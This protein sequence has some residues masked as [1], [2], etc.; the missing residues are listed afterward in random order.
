MD[1]RFVRLGLTVAPA[2]V[3]IACGT[4]TAPTPREL[5]VERAQWQAQGLTNYSYVWEQI[6]GG[7][8]RS[9]VFVATGDTVPGPL[10]WFPTID[11]MFDQAIAAANGHTLHAIVFDHH[12]HYPVRMD[13]DG[14]AD[15]S[16]S[17]LASEL[18]PAP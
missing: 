14:P 2:L 9:A 3:L 1:T 15:A 8:L 7:V 5:L 4:P 13:L 6:G 17:V 16:G 12:Y 10:T 18:T 11:Q